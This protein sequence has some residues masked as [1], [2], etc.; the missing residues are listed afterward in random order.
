MQAL[1]DNGLNKIVD[2][3]HQL[4]SYDEMLNDLDSLGLK[5]PECIRSLLSTKKW[6][7][8]KIK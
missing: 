3:Q 4:Y 5:F 8:L 6:T 7:R 2:T 1:T